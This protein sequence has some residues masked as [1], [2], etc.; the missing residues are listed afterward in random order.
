MLQVLSEMISPVELLACVAL[1]ELVHVLQV[2][3]ARFPVSIGN[4]P[5]GSRRCVSRASKLL[6]TIPANVGIARA[7]G[8]VVK[9]SL[10][11]C[12]CRA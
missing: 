4:E 3:N 10:V 7:R 9:G 11:A 2:P 5:P 1:P 12:Q 6:A 8:A